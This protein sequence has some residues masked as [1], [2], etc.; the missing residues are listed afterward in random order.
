MEA[1][2]LS[3]V[4][5]NPLLSRP[6][7]R[8]RSCRGPA[9]PETNLEGH[10]SAQP[11]CC[12]SRPF[13]QKR[14]RLGRKQQSR[15]QSERRPAATALAEVGARLPIFFCYDHPRRFLPRVLVRIAI[16]RKPFRSKQ[17]TNLA[18]A[19]RLR[20]A[21]TIAVEATAFLT[22][23]ALAICRAARSRAFTQIALNVP[24]PTS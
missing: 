19:W 11:D 22:V 24:L 15:M 7:R 10:T 5:N 18:K 20:G 13:T 9:Q 2:E 14:P 1:I 23:R 12:A 17:S 6:W 21:G 4:T 3:C 8:R 16:S